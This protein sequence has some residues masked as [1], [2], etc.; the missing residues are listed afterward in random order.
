MELRELDP[1][2][3]QRVRA[4]V[5]ATAGASPEAWSWTP[6]RIDREWRSVWSTLQLP[7][8]TILAEDEGRILGMVCCTIVPVDREPGAVITNLCVTLPDRR[9]GIGRLL[10]LRAHDIARAAG[11]RVA[12]LQVAPTQQ[13]A[14]Q[15]YTALGYSPVK[16]SEDTMVM[17]LSGTTN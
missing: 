15:L 12:A 6:A 14:V 17:D 1:Q 4:F 8:A 7:V 11:A 2:D 16:E 10:M 13:A 9:R 5:V 3:E